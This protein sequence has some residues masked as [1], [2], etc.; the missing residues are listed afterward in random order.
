MA[1]SGI[2]DFSFRQNNPKACFSFNYK[3]N[4]YK[5]NTYQKNYLSHFYVIH[6]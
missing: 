6:F 3:T 4:R 1:Y 2:L 5:N